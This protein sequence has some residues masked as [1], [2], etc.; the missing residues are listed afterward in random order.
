MRYVFFASERAR[1]RGER[2]KVCERVWIWGNN[3]TIV[4]YVLNKL[5]S[6]KAADLVQ[7]REDFI[8]NKQ[9]RFVKYFFS[10]MPYGKSRL[11]P[12]KVMEAS[13]EKLTHLIRVCGLLLQTKVYL[14]WE[15]KSRYPISP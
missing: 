11:Y 7:V 12:G 3:L 6:L 14:F 15:K 5:Q 13:L 9:P 1:A 4:K 10:G 8:K 2:V